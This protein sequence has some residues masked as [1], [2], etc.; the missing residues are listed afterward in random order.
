MAKTKT[1][2]RGY[3][4]GKCGGGDHN[5]RMNFT[6]CSPEIIEEGVRRLG[7]TMREMLE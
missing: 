5:A 3:K 6:F 2:K 4:C 1:K 7:E